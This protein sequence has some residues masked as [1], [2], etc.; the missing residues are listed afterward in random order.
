MEEHVTQEDL[1]TRLNQFLIYDELP[2]WSAPFGLTL[3]DTL[4]LKPGIKILDIGSGAG[5]P[6]LE[7]AE[8][9]GKTSF[10]YG[11]DPSEDS[12]GMITEKMRLKGISNASVIRGAA[13]D[14][15]FS[16]CFFGLIVANNGV[17]NVQDEGKVLAECHRVLVPDGQMVLTMNLP[18]TFV[19]FYDV[20]DQVLLS[21]GLTEESDRLREHIFTKRKPVEYWKDKILKAGFTI[22]SINMD[23]FKMRFMNGTA[24]LEHSFIRRAFRRSWEEVTGDPGIFRDVEE[25][26]NK[27]ASLNGELTMSVPYACFDCHKTEPA[28]S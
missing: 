22:R 15:P 5:F 6:M 24:F 14:L 9:A 12:I 2:L 25:Q 20:Y 18:H 4:V 17:N 21:R 7:I 8:R 28:G 26:M 19:E 16:D 23:G 10:V 3:M 1:M 27:I 13:E 11:I